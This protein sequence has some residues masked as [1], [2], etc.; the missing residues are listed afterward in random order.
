MRSQSKIWAP[1]STSWRSAPQVLAE[2]ELTVVDLDVA[3]MEFF[4]VMSLLR[5][6]KGLQKRHWSGSGTKSSLSSRAEW[7]G[8][9]ISKFKVSAAIKGCRVIGATGFAVAI[10]RFRDCACIIHLLNRALEYWNTADGS[11]KFLHKL[12][13]CR[14]VSGIPKRYAWVIQNAMTS[15]A[16]GVSFQFSKAFFL[17]HPVPSA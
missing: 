12:D 15:C 17:P 16:I 3:E 8:S 4:F 13:G 14:R 7:W 2:T 10:W 9:R 11:G 6:R 5:P 1:V